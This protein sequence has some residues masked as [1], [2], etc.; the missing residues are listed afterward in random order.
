MKGMVI[1]MAAKKENFEASIKKL[2]EIVLKLE[3][4]DTSLDESLEL[5]ESGVKLMKVC[6][7]MLDEAE[8]KVTV[9]CKEDDK[10]VEKEFVSEA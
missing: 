3:A 5:F 7:K 4:G 8:Q 10:I 9:L 2:E 6:Q 1:I